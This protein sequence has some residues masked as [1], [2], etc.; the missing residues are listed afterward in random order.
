MKDIR[1]QRRDF[2]FLIVISL[3]FLSFA[4]PNLQYE[5]TNQDE[6]KMGMWALYIFKDIH[7]PYIWFGSSVDIVIK[8]I[9]FPINFLKPHC[10]ALPYYMVFPFV[11]MLGLNI[12]PIKILPILTC[13]LTLPLLYY[14]LYVFL[15]RR[16]AMLATLFLATSFG[17]IHFARLGCM[18]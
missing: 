15:N 16:V 9:R 14:I 10:F 5:W 7:N 4:L 12:Y 3:V 18:P 2:F 17:F 8:N 13:L 11:A 6:I 1:F